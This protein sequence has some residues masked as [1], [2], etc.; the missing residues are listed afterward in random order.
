M[1]SF[2]IKIGAVQN[3]VSNTKAQST[4]IKQIS[5]D[6]KSCADALSATMDNT[7]VV[8]AV[9]RIASNILEEAAKEATFA[10][11][12]KTIAGYYVSADSSVATGSVT[13]S[14]QMVNNTEGTDKRSAWRKFWDW[15]LRR[16]VDKNYT[17]TSDEQ[18][19][20]ADREL[21]RRV[22]DLLKQERFSEEHWKQ[23]TTE[24]RKEIL[25][26]YMREVSAILGVEV[27]DNIIWTNTP[28]SNGTIN[29][30]SYKHSERAV[31]INEYNL[32][33]SGYNSYGLMTTIVHELR[34]AYQHN[35]I[36]HPDRYRVSKE[37]IDSWKRSFDTYNEEQAKGYE[38]YRRIV[39]E[40]DARRFAGQD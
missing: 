33:M 37:T 10:E 29:R 28:P 4:R 21:Q 2:D 39:V 14:V 31:R 19:K 34:H 8:D 36:E 30:G 18:E 23:A 3:E 35:A 7:A 9:R 20:A 38:S 12:L 1:S 5:R 26:D 22:Q 13:D 16:N 40:V 17:S 6:V 25:Q 32:T 27:A 15:I 11:A 24:E